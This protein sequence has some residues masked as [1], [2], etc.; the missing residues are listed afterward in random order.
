MHEVHGVCG[1]YTCKALAMHA[2][3]A[4]R[5]TGDMLCCYSEVSTSRV[6]QFHTAFVGLT[7]V[8]SVY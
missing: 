5:L 6:Q 1:Y 2:L 8:S 7:Y 3:H 4:Q